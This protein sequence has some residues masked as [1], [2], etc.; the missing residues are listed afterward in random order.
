MTRLGT[1]AVALALAG[2]CAHSA[3]TLPA[4]RWGA[5]ATSRET[6]T[7]VA[8]ADSAP[9]PAARPS[10]SAVTPASAVQRITEP[11][12]PPSGDAAPPAAAAEP[13]PPPADPKALLSALYQQAAERYAPMDSYIARLRR[14]EQVNGRDKPEETLLLKFRRQ[15]F[16]VYFKWLGNEGAGREVVYV[17]GRYG[18]QIHTLLAAGDMPLVPAG[19]RMALA[20]DNV[21]VRAASRHAITDTG[22]GHLIERFGALVGGPGGTTLRYAGRQKRPEF[23]HPVD[24]VEQ[25]IPPNAEGQLPQGGRRLWAFDPI[26]HL[27]CLVVTSDHTGHEVEYYCY[28]WVQF[29]VHLDDDDFNPDKLWPSARR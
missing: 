23:A 1:W 20:P 27:P 29:P 5:G 12:A 6:A 4:S 11:G 17:A 10:S 16:S 14:R 21:F 19:R 24:V 15:P 7:P 9:A 22:L 25:L 8:K 26:G 2:G 28:D 3:N 13:A 18:G